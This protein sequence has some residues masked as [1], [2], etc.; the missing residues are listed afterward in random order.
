MAPSRLQGALG[1]VSIDR[2]RELVNEEYRWLQNLINRLKGKEMLM[3]REEFLEYLSPEHWQ[4]ERDR[5][6]GKNSFEILQALLELGIVMQSP[7]GRINVPELY[8]YGFGLKRKGG[9]KRPK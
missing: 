4:E 2:V 5:L 6:P 1:E 8:L 7:D 3:E 9:I